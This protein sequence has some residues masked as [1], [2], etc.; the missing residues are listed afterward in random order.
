[1]VCIFYVSP[2]RELQLYLLRKEIYIFICNIRL[3]TAI[4]QADWLVIMYDYCHLIKVPYLTEKAP[5]ALKKLMQKLNPLY[6]HIT[7]PGVDI[8]AEA[9]MQKCRLENCYFQ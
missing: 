6:V 8:W 3:L 4:K 7:A 1:M 9:L 5:W 2:V